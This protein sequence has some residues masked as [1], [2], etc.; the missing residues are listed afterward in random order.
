MSLR[1]GDFDTRAEILRTCSLPDLR[2][3]FATVQEKIQLFEELLENEIDKEDEGD[4]SISDEDEIGGIPEIAINEFVIEDVPS[5]KEDDPNEGEDPQD[6]GQEEDIEEQLSDSSDED[7]HDLQQLVETLQTFVDETSK[8]HFIT[9][10][11]AVDHACTVILL[12]IT[13]AMYVF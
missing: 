5:E 12:C 7:D 11:H 4:P 9:T 2:S 6:S 1:E 8:P 13:I 3:L 10:L